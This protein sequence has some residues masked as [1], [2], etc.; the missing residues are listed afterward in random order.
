[1]T[2]LERVISGV[3]N[4]RPVDRILP[5]S[6]FHTARE[7]LLLKTLNNLSINMVWPLLF[8]NNFSVNVLKTHELRSLRSISLSGPRDY[9]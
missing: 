3:L 4:R 7:E 9:F 6:A 8:I 5:A 2:A 1:M